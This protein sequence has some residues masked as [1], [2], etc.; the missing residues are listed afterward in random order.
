MENLNQTQKD[1]LKSV[2]N[3]ELYKRIKKQF[4]IV[5]RENIKLNDTQ[6]SL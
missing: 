3:P 1:Y 4:R 2:K 6:K 5:N